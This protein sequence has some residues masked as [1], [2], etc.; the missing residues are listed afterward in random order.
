MLPAV[1][2]SSEA[3]TYLT[4]AG[5]LARSLSSAPPGSRLPS[6][7]ELAR[8]YGLHRQTARAVL[9][10]L[11]RRHLVRRVQG[12]GTFVASLIDYRV[13]PAAVPSFSETVRR[14]G[15][16][17]RSETERIRLR[18]APAAVRAELG[19]DAGSPVYLLTRR[20]FVDDEL[21]GCGDTYLAADLVPELPRRLRGGASLYE[22]LTE[23]YGLEPVRTV[24]RAEVELASE[25]VT[26]RLGLDAQP[27]TIATRGVAECARLQRPIEVTAGWLRAD[28]F[29]LVVEF[30]GR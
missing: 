24:Y 1:S 18:A 27:W 26:R 21:V 13:S 10:E 16:V 17:P 7:N 4:V 28:V 2:T 12:R 6:E 29:R 20:R 5:V 3:P 14:T 9:Q 25:R 15:A 22:A 8:T 11:E 30:G 19:L 23:D